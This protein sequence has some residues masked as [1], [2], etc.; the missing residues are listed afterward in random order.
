MKT[1]IWLASAFAAQLFGC[2]AW[3]VTATPVSAVEITSAPVADIELYPN[4]VYEGR[5]VYLYDNRWYYRDGSQ[6]RYYRAEPPP[7][8]QHRQHLHAVPP[9]YVEIPAPP[10]PNIQL[11]PS[12]VYAG[13]PVYLY[14]NRWYY[15]EGQRWRYYRQ[16]PPP[17]IQERQRHRAQPPPRDDR[18]RREPHDR[19][20]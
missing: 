15:R 11:Y 19:D 18:Y 14:D 5:T 17:L 9:P 20:R 13:R 3:T 6:W 12:T 8:A 2:G 16:E 10:V 7:L 4:T 1:S